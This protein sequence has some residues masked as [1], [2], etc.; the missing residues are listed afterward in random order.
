[1][2]FDTTP[3]PSFNAS[4]PHARFLNS[5]CLDLLFIEL[6]PMAER[7]VQELEANNAPDGEGVAGGK[8]LD[9]EELREATFYKLESLGYRVGLGLAERL[10]GRRI[11]RWRVLGHGCGRSMTGYSEAVVPRPRGRN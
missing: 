9:E 2:S 6:V 7:L 3:T 8:A 11:Q 1:M 5:S 10:L 4:D